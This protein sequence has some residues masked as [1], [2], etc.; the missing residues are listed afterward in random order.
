MSVIDER[1]KKDI[2]RQGKKERL[3]K[4]EPKRVA[5]LLRVS[6]RKQSNDDE[7]PIPVQR[8]KLLEM[9][10]KSPDWIPATVKGEILEYTEV[11]S[12][13]KLTKKERESLEGAIEDAYNDFYDVLLFF[14]GDRLSRLSDEYIPLLQTFW[15]LGVEPW[16][17]EKQQPLTLKTQTDKLMRYIEG[18]QAETESVNT[19]YRVTEHMRDYAEEGHWMGGQVPYGYRYKEPVIVEGNR[20]RK[21]RMGIEIEPKEAKMVKQIFQLYVNGYGSTKICRV[22]NNPPY[23]YRKR[24]GKPFEH[25]AILNI[26]KNPIYIGIITWGKTSYKNKYFQRIPEEEWVKSDMIEELRIIDEELFENA[27]SLYK[28]R[29]KQAKKGKT[30]SRR[31]MASNRL[32]AGIA[33]CGYCG[34]PFLSKSYSNPKR[35]YK[36]EGY[37][38]RSR[39]RR[40]PCDSTRGFWEKE[41][42]E[43]LVVAIIG[44]VV[45][46]M[47]SLDLNELMFRV[48]TLYNEEKN[49][50]Y[51]QIKQISDT[52]KGLKKQENYYIEQFNK[53]L[54]GEEIGLPISVVKE[55]IK[56]VNNEIKKQSQLADKLKKESSENAINEELLK[57]LVS[58]MGDWEITFQDADIII[59][60]KMIAQLVESIQIYD[61]EIK[62]NFQINIQNILGCAFKEVE[63]FPKLMNIWI[64]CRKEWLNSW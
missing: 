9:I 56:R 57:T 11:G 33:Y 48:R 52:L 25:T 17:Y 29:S 45:D 13:F 26:I 2:I 12:A 54:S 10:A 55:Q 18:W 42:L 62:I 32:L 44:R 30:H 22:L 38:C 47:I 7:V 24:N 4:G 16:D 34:E 53:H 19:A 15:D 1:R 60:R 23:N 36:R 14:K 28:K 64:K 43:G 61:E 5:L 21:V 8:K 39:K 20:R 41:E 46:E 27:Q 59:K 51:Q 40:A 49:N 31:M 3:A 50:N 63:E 35:N 6:T 58:F 37:T